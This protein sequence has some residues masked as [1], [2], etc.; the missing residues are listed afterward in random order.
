M[1]GASAPDDLVDALLRWAPMHLVF[2]HDAVSAGRAGLPY[3][4]PADPGPTALLQALRRAATGRADAGAGG[5]DAEVLLVLPAAGDVRGL[6]AGT[7][8]AAA[9]LDAG[10]GV[11]VGPPGH[12][13]IGVVATVEGP[14]VV[15]WTV[16]DVPEIPL[17]YHATG[18]GEAEL[19]MREAV[20]D[21][22]AAVSELSLVAGSATA[23][24]RA[25]ADALSS[26]AAHT[27]PDSLP[28][29][30]LRILDS[31]DHVDAILT[32]ARDLAGP[33]DNASAVALERQLR[34]LRTAVRTA[35]AAAINA[36]SRVFPAR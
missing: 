32:A 5:A 21:A 20:R 10:G 15:R 23:A 18:L 17:G 30:A 7:E 25:V 12:P 24:Q 16:H 4:E 31:A 9:A 2:A 36:D 3:P 14:D 1:R 35:R 29:R 11:S 19:A 22:A 34:P 6:P 8:F 27:Y 33:V 28:P 26:A 13:G